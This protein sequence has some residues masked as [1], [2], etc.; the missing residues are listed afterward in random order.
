MLCS[1]F[2]QSLLITNKT[3]TKAI[4]GNDDGTR[5]Y[6]MD[7]IDELDD[8]AVT[9]EDVDMEIAKRRKFISNMELQNGA[10]YGANEI[11]IEKQLERL[12]NE[13]INF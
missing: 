10:D 11:Q 12:L 9:S 8:D 13:Q 3:K 5:D 4:N 1:S 7:A 6:D 2:I